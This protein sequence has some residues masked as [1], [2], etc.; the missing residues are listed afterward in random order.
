MKITILEGARGTGKS[1][2]AF[3]L[4]QRM[5][6]TTLINFT[7]FKDDGEAGLFKIQEYYFSWLR[8]IQSLSNH[9]STYIFDRFYF[10][11]MVFSSLYKEYNFG[12]VFYSL[13]EHLVSLSD[14]VEIDIIFLA[15]N[16]NEE[17]EK[18]L[19]R[20]KIPF[21]NVEESVNQSLIQQEM[22]MTIFKRL[23]GKLNI[24]MIDTSCKTNEEV[25]DEI[26]KTI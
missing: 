18:R 25:Y 24:H 14:T 26:V 12:T 16:D 10:S 1:T 7:G 8:L 2:L 21:A 6:S 19:I 4:R 9:D 5:E 3:K 23:C 11:E 20:D 13:N 22:Y 17:L 15:I